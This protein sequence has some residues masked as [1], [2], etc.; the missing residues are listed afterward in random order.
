MVKAQFIWKLKKGILFWKHSSSIDRIFPNESVKKLFKAFANIFC[1]AK[2][3][4]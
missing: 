1:S 2:L 4:K 3:L